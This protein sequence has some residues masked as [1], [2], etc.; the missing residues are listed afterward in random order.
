VSTDKV[1]VRSQ[2][3]NCAPACQGQCQYYPLKEALDASQ[4]VIRQVI[5]LDSEG[6][7][8]SAAVWCDMGEHAFSARNP[9]RKRRVE[10]SIDPVSGEEIT[11]QMDICGPCAVGETRGSTRTAIMP[12]QADAPGYVIPPGADQTQADAPG[13]YAGGTGTHDVPEDRIYRPEPGDPA[14]RP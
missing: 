1:W 12:A 4:A 7:N 2:Q 6:Q 13:Y 3:Y 5:G 10:T 8:M 9:G 14:V 11:V